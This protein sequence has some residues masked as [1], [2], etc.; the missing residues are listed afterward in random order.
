[1]TKFKKCHCLSNIES[2]I[3]QTCTKLEKINFSIIE[4][5][6]VETLL[7]WKLA[8]MVCFM[9]NIKSFEITG[10]VEEEVEVIAEAFKCW[11]PHDAQEA[12][13]DDYFY[14]LNWRQHEEQSES[15]LP[16]TAR[17]L[18]GYE[19][20]KERLVLILKEWR[21]VEDKMA[22]FA[23]SQHM[24]LGRDSIAIQID[25]ALLVMILDVV[26]GRTAHKIATDAILFNI[27][28]DII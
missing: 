19:E 1:M 27:A 20:T 21:L 17:E 3:F 15:T 16:M 22:A 26:M 23:M 10:G 7:F 28:C 14:D 9:R 5:R 13:F 24:R 4:P 6:P 2:N 25:A 11:P 8:Q 18:G 12:M